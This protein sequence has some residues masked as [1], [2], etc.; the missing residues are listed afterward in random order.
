MLN[1]SWN[2]NIEPPV[3]AEIE[4]HL[5]PFLW[6]IPAWCHE[7]TVSMWNSEAGNG[8]AI[9]TG[10]QYEYR[11]AHMDF[12]S[13]WLT[14]TDYNKG[15]HVVHDLLHVTNSIY[16]DYAEGVIG[17]LCTKEEAPRYHA[18]IFEE[19]RMLCEGM[20]QDLAKAIFERFRAF[21]Q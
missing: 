9:R 12:Y 13:V 10:I 11:K 15:L 14:E 7:L 6:L 21:P 18:Q 1:V 3:K 17:R 2:G 20:T 5:A 8:A 4:K 19:S 16:V